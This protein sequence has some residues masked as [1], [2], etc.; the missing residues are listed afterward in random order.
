MKQRNILIS[1]ASV[2]GPA[3]AFWLHRHGGFRVTVVDHGN[4][5]ECGGYKVDLRGPATDLIAR[6]GIAREVRARGA[7]LGGVTVLDERG[8]VLTK[9][10]RG[11]GFLEDGDLQVL[12]GDLS[13]ILYDATAND[14]EYVFGDAIASISQ[15]PDGVTVTF[16][17]GE[18]RKFDLV[19][20]ADGIYSNVR[21]LVLGADVDF[22]RDLGYH[23]AGFSIPNF[24]ELDRWG[25]LYSMPNQL[26]HVYSARGRPDAQV[27]FL[28]DLG[29]D[30]ALPLRY[31]KADRKQQKELVAG[32][33]A[34]ASWEMPRILEAMHTAE[35]FYFDSVSVVDVDGWSRQRVAL[36]GDA[37]WGPSFASGQGTSQAIVGG[38]VLAGELA[39]ARDRHEVAFAGYETVMKP[40]TSM[41]QN[42]GQALVQHML[43]VSR[44]HHLWHMRFLK[45]LPWLPFARSLARRFQRAQRPSKHITLADYGI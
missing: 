31:G 15:Q 44:G 7:D 29:S 11:F 25:F 23:V 26:A 34:D 41:N 38:Y 20:G 27:G 13:R 1:G 39:A 3:L 19:V 42:L 8:K 18:P 12:R 24:L 21:S 2:A 16:Q 22:L 5:P 40:W 4:V 37:A 30:H 9:M 17:H 33:F 32:L 36:V 43:G 6:M 28:F 14:T 45:L 10:D 35:D